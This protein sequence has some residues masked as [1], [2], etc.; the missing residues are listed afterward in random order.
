M[1]LNSRCA[2]MHRKATEMPITDLVTKAVEKMAFRQGF[3][4]LKFKNQNGVAFHDADWIAG[5][6]CKED[7]EDKKK[8]KKMKN[9][10]MNVLTR[11]KTMTTKKTTLKIAMKKKLIK[12]RSMTCCKKQRKRKMSI[13]VSIKTI[14]MNRM[15]RNNRTKTL[16]DKMTMLLKQAKKMIHK[17]MNHQVDQQGNQNQQ[18][19]SNQR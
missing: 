18:R 9:K 15:D 16:Y 2:V 7:T 17:Q 5:V 11:M 8:Q 4:N 14:K 13:T 19:D 10:M 1:D 12:T 3:K 6:D